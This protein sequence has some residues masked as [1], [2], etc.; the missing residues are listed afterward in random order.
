MNQ[1]YEEIELLRRKMYQKYEQDPNDPEILMISQMLDKLL[2]D[3][4]SR[5]N[6]EER[7]S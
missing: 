4:Q 7:S 1:L 6:R 3:L 2:N 5:Q